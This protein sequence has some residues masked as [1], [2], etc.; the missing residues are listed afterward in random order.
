MVVLAA[1]FLV[2]LPGGG[3]ICPNVF[4]FVRELSQNVIIFLKGLGHKILFL[5]LCI[6]FTG[7]F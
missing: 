4:H 7:A 6:W 2:L 5:F 3:G 1:I